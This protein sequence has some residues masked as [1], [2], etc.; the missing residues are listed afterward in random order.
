MDFQQILNHAKRG[1]HQT[2][3]LPGLRHPSI[4]GSLEFATTDIDTLKK[5]NCN[6]YAGHNWVSVAKRGAACI[7]D[8]DNSAEAERRGF[9]IPD[10]TFIVKSP[11]GGLHAYYWHTPES[12]ELG[13]FAVLDDSG[14][15]IVEFKSH[16]ATCASPGVTRTDKEPHGEYIPENCLPLVKITIDRLEWLK[17]NRPV[18]HQGT[19]SNRK[20]RFHPTFD[21]FDVI[22]HFDWSMTGKDMTKSGARYLEF[23]KCPH[24]GDIHEGMEK[25][26][27]FK[28]CLVMGDYGLGFDCKAG[29]CQDMTF[30]DLLTCMYEDGYEDY[31]YC[32]YE[33]EDDNLIHDD[34]AWGGIEDADEVE[35]L[36]PE[37]VAAFLSSPDC[38]ASEPDVRVVEVTD[39]SFPPE[40]MYGTLGQIAGTLDA[41]LGFAYPAMLAVGAGHGIV[42][43]GDNVRG[44]MYVVLVGDIGDGKTAVIQRSLGSLFLPE[45]T[46]VKITPGSDRG[47]IKLLGTTGSPKLLIQ[48]EFRNTMSKCNIQ[49]SSLAPLL[50]SLW[51]DNIA[52]AADKRGVEECDAQLSILGNLACKDSTDFASVFG[53]QT[54]K[55]LTD[56]FVIGLGAPMKFMPTKIKKDLLEVKPCRVPGWAFEAKERWQG[57][58]RERRRLGEIALRVALITSALNG[59][60]EVTKEAMEKALLFC[61][62]QERVRQVYRPGIAENKEAE[63]FEAV[64]AA[65]NEKGIGVPIPWSRTMNAKSYYRKYSPTLLNRVKKALKDEGIITFEMEEDGQGRPTKKA[66]GNVILRGKVK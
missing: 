7:L 38:E 46:V 33:D 44:T 32:I 25:P 4:K 28:C 65:L 53:S 50:C 26:G 49:G 27:N 43:A 66:T 31:P 41:P 63:C 5:W 21:H 10:D 42:D 57:D 8:I 19:Y 52:G 64:I 17:A 13:N 62:W 30:G 61:E 15:P 16:N 45:A 40:C 23:A 58:I 22:D 24:K 29:S 12:E 34:P 36:S 37:A 20:R 11:S 18:K 48:D 3:T 14:N 51:S 59:D 39:I 35:K 9:P 56:R 47:L 6:G 60:P 54:T 1:V 2:P 55:G